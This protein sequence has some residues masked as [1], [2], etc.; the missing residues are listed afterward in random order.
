MKYRQADLIRVTEA[1]KSDPK[2][3]FKRDFSR[4]REAFLVLLQHNCLKVVIPELTEDDIVEDNKVKIQN[5]IMYRIDLDSVLDRLRVP[6]ALSIMLENFGDIGM[7]IAEEFFLQAARR[8]VGVDDLGAQRA[9]KVHA[10]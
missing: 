8:G 1:M 5:K 7:W 9:R 3:D 2:F 10:A 4:V 6:K